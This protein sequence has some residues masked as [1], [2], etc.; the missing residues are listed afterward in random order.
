MSH[1]QSDT[2]PRSLFTVARAAVEALRIPHWVKNGIVFFPMLFAV[3]FVDPTAWMASSLAALTFCFAASAVYLFN[4]IL[5]RRLDQIHPRKRNRPIASGR[6]PIPVA[7]GES[8]LLLVAVAGL[9]LHLGVGFLLVVTIYLGMQLCY[10]VVLKRKMLVDAICLACGFVLRAVGGAVVISVE[11]SPWLV[12]CSF[13]LCLFLGF[14]KRHCEILAISD[15][16]QAAQHRKTL[17][18]YTPQL[19]IHLMTLSATITVISFLLYATSPR[20]LHEFH[21]D[22]FLYTVPLVIYGVCRIAMQ[23]M[24]GIF[25]GPTEILLRDRAVQAAAAL[26]LLLAVIIVTYGH[27]IQEWMGGLRY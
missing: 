20:T 25:D 14:C 15:G 21:T 4:D 9:C 10:S 3:R 23:S 19:L 12:I 26:W 16:E 6:L 24:R 7:L 11:I 17:E 22:L 1:S 5:D 8:V 2:T 13:A 27:T 18:G